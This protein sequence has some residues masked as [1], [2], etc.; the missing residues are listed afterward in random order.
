MRTT[1]TGGTKMIYNGKIRED[2]SCNNIGEEKTIGTSVWSSSGGNNAYLGYKI[3]TLNA[4]A[5]AKAHSN[6]TDSEV[7]KVIDEWYEH[8]ILGKD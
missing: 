1:E 4:A 6:S 8:N 7:K 3:G 5:Y 2:G